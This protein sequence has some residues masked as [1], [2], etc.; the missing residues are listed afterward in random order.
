MSSEEFLPSEDITKL[1]MIK[2]KILVEVLDRDLKSAAGIWYPQA[3]VNRKANPIWR[4]KVLAVGPGSFCKK[5]KRVAMDVKVGDVV[6]FTRHHGDII[7]KFNEKRK[8]R[9][10]TTQDPCQLLA[11]DDNPWKREE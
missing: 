11:F 6:L 3:M 2:D 4:G 7:D 8:L 9:V 10:L 5:G 1:R